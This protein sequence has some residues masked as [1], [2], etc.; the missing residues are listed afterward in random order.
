MYWR[1]Q[2]DNYSNGMK[3]KAQAI[4]DFKRVVADNLAID[5]SVL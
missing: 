5:I 1:D 4:A 2:V 3:T